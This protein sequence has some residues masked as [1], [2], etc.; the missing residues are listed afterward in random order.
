MMFRTSMMRTKTLGPLYATT[1][2]RSKAPLR[3]ATFCRKTG[4][5]PTTNKFNNALEE[6]R[7]VPQYCVPLVRFEHV[8]GLLCGYGSS[9]RICQ[10][11]QQAMAEA[12]SALQCV[13][14]A[15]ITRR[16]RR[17]SN[18]GKTRPEAR[19]LKLL[20]CRPDSASI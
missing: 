3:F 6:M 14:L 20:G 17:A 10:L 12:I 5:G 8:R 13:A 11:Y 15:V 7:S 18:S 4:S 9:R 2:Q 19:G 16:E 1:M